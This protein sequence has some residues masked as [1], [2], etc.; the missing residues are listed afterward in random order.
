VLCDLYSNSTL[1]N[2]LHYRLYTR[3]FQTHTKLLEE[4]KT[5]LIQNSYILLQTLD[6]LSYYFPLL[7]FFSLLLF[8]LLLFL[9]YSIF[10]FS[11]LLTLVI[12]SSTCFFCLH[13]AHITSLEHD[14]PNE[15]SISSIIFP[16]ISHA[17]SVH[18][19]RIFPKT[20]WLLM[21]AVSYRSSMCS[22]ELSL[23]HT[24]YS[25]HC[26]IVGVCA[27]NWRACTI[28]L[29]M[30]TTYPKLWVLAWNY[31]AHGE[32]PSWDLLW[33]SPY[34]IDGSKAPNHLLL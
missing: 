11:S 22:I 20:F 5:W 32:H 17:F 8:F 23:A 27:Q 2:R 29:C 30:D 16:M 25:F 24:P 34:I 26:E 21:H 7:H 6:R 9:W 33:V 3:L 31:D 14:N 10:F 18:Y 19:S 12:S 1:I 28:D 15:L 4:I 13:A